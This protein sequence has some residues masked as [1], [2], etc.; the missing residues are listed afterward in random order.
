MMATEATAQ[1]P[2]DVSALDPSHTD[3]AVANSGSR[4]V[5][6]SGT[7]L[8]G[9]TDEV[10]NRQ[11]ADIVD[12]L[13]NS[14]EASVSGG[15]DTEAFKGDPSKSLGD[16]GHARNSS[17]IKKPQSFK[18]VS[19][20]RTFLA[21]KS[22]SNSNA[23]P[24]S[25]PGSTSATPQPTVASSASRLKLV[26]K[27]GSNLGGSTKTLSTNG[28][29]TSA[30]DPNL[31][32]NRNRAPP[33]P[34]PKKISDEELVKEY[35]IHMAHRL[36][37]EDIKGESNWA[38]IEDDDEW[39]PDT[40]TWTDGTKVTLPHSEEPPASQPPAPPSVNRDAVIAP[41][42]KSP[43]PAASASGSPSVKPGVLAS[44]KGLVLKGAPEKPTLVAKPPAPP[45]PVKS[46][47]APLPP[48]EKLPP[49]VMDLPHHAQPSRYPLRDASNTK[50]VTP[51]PPAKEIAADD[52]SRSAWRDNHHT[53]PNKELFNSQSGRYEPVS[54]RRGSRNDIHGRQPA[55]L[56]RPSHQEQ[57][58]PAEPSAAFQTS[59]TSGQEAPYP[60]GR[61][62]GSSNVSG[63]SGNFAH[64]LGIKTHDMGPPPVDM[65]QAHGQPGSI[66]SGAESPVSHRTFS[67]ANS[68][69]ALRSNPSQTYQP[70]PSPVP[71]QATPYQH[72]PNPEAL[73]Q[74]QFENQKKYMTAQAREEEAKKARIAE[75]LKALGPA[76]ERKSAKK[77]AS[78]DETLV[79]S[80]VAQRASVP[81]SLTA[82]SGSGDPSDKSIEPVSS[83]S[84]AVRS[85][86]STSEKPV[87]Q[88]STTT[89][90]NNIISDH[91][92]PEARINGGPK[93]AFSQAE[94]TYGAA[95][96]SSAAM[97]SHQPVRPWPGT[98]QHQERLHS[99]SRGTQSASNNVWAPPGSSSGLGNGVFNSDIAPLPEANPVPFSQKSHPGPIAPPRVTPQDEPLPPELAPKRLDPIAPPQ[100]RSKQYAT[101]KPS[102]SPD[103]RA[104]AWKGFAAGIKGDDV[105]RREERLKRQSQLD[106]STFNPRTQDTWRSVEIDKNGKRTSLG[107]HVEVSSNAPASWNNRSMNGSARGR[108]DGTGTTAEL[109]GPD[110]IRSRFG[111]QVPVGPSGT[112]APGPPTQARSESRFFPTSKEAQQPEVSKHHDIRTKSP[113][114]PPPTADGHPVYDGDAT[115]PHVALPPQKIR[116]KLPPSSQATTTSPN[117]QASKS[118]PISFAAAA[119]ASISQRGPVPGTNARPSSRGVGY[120]SIPQTSNEIKSQENWQDR[121]NVLMGKKSASPAKSMPVDSSSKVAIEHTQSYDTPVSLPPLSPSRTNSTNSSITSKEMAEECFGEQEMGSLPNVRLPNDAPDAAWQAVTPNWNPAPARLRV[122]PM[123]AEAISFHPEFSNGK[124]LI[125]ISTPGMAD[126]RTVTAPL[127]PNSR[128]HSN[129]RRSG[130]RGGARRISRGGQRGVRDSSEHPMDLS[131]ASSSG[132]AMSNRGGRNHNH[133]PRTENW[134]RHASSTPAAQS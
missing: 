50:S 6:P 35:G 12:D 112:T 44:G 85:D 26:A 58:G 124:T 65:T 64:R 89:T 19:V 70:R 114:P 8:N 46:P 53:N 49:V 5:D 74:E 32:W 29:P 131:L 90:D 22:A 54:D 99:W 7:T 28:K 13:V 27:S 30:P 93:D 77:E 132:R 76:P 92:R 43:A 126:V 69:P 21:S 17:T 37:P 68:Q 38:D 4:Y 100:G 87:P 33:P 61:R 71:S 123:C 84:G 57:Q 86:V 63:G 62:R 130:P 34:E 60:Y 133:R 111:R 96:Q 119:A 3:T 67:P 134:G 81:G 47:W 59:R 15:S 104:G 25:T 118:A 98:S 106:E 23:R 72:Q 31:V 94:R 107:T 88:V 79:P 97:H 48:V 127:P 102:T 11:I 66:A 115:R 110:G 75:K 120:G 113:T 2:V 18:S 40:I 39:E 24:E 128:S 52:F 105:E 80:H 125:R 103:S 101:Q 82:R 109:G 83:A 42:P 73:T 116:V 1:N 9:S 121:I 91:S 95:T 117:T 41:K 36:G 14:A 20:N 51:P 56:Q 55:V 129:P 78:K 108:P 122:D 45:T 16:K 10:E